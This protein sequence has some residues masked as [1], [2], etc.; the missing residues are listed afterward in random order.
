MFQKLR[1]DLTQKLSGIKLLIINAEGF[2]A[3]NGDG[4]YNGSSL[5]EL[6]DAEVECVMFSESSA[7]E[8]STAAESLGVVLYQGVREKLE[9]YKKLKEEYSVTDGD[10]AFICRDGSDLPLMRRVNFTAVTRDADLDVKKE[11][12]YAANGCGQSA[13]REIAL[14]ITKA[15][16][17]PNGWSE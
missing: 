13:L 7:E 11:S 2:G 1:S 16:N 9:F 12:Y 4:V 10:I 14:I 6:R 8:I 3:D 17:Y 15:K 5:D